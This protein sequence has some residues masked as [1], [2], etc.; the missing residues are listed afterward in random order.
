MGKYV[1]KGDRV[2]DLRFWLVGTAA[3]D[4][5]LGAVFI[6]WDTMTLSPY[7]AYRVCSVNKLVKITP[8]VLQFPH[9]GKIRQFWEK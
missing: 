1:K 6:D 7:N 4:Q 9:N 3:T 2:L 5:L 8:N